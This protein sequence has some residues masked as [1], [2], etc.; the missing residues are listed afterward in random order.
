[1]A[2]CCSARCAI[3]PLEFKQSSIKHELKVIAV[4]LSRA[5]ILLNVK[6][7]P[8]AKSFSVQKIPRYSLKKR[9]KLQY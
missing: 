9:L 2:L 6:M 1:M 3:R 7:K 4:R 8:I 5:V